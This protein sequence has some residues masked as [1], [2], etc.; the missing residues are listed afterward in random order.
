MKDS[1]L[2]ALFCEYLLLWAHLPGTWQVKA[3]QL[4]SL[5]CQLPLFCDRAWLLVKSR[6]TR[7]A[8]AIQRSLLMTE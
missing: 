5:L 8:K 2:P 7:Q 3:T 6:A 4:D 1:S